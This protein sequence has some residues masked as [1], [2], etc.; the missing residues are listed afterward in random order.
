MAKRFYVA[1]EALAK[2][3]I[4]RSRFYRLVSSG[5]IKPIPQPDSKQSVYSR[6]EI[7][8]LASELLQFRAAMNDA[9]EDEMLVFRQAEPAD[10]DGVYEV[11]HSLFGHTSSADMRRPMIEA[12]PQG[13]YIVVQGKEIVAFVHIQPLQPDRLDAFM[14]GEIRGWDLTAN[15]LNCFRVGEQ[16]DCLVKSIGATRKYGRSEQIRF[17]RRLLSG[18]VRELI[19]MGR[20]GIR[21]NK[22]YATSPYEEGQKICESADMEEYSKPLGDRRT[23]V[24]DVNQSNSKP[25]EAYRSALM[26]WL[27]SMERGG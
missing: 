10:M 2:L 13:N 21:I 26:D 4:S 24:V 15:D 7:D 19:K 3:E 9:S 20:S 16:F 17:A 22:L 11:A 27:Q 5:R 18:T 23:Y 8:L 1:K 12:C 25:Y 6:K 14:R